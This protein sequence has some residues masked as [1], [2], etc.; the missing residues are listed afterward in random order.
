MKNYLK[1]GLN[2]QIEI[3]KVLGWK[4][5]I[6]ALLVCGY[7]SFII[8]SITV[9]LFPKKILFLIISQLIITI[10]FIFFI[11]KHLYEFT[12]KNERSRYKK[13]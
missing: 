7:M 10:S 8:G 3:K 4:K 9:G 2:K 5:Y 1:G 12:I 11:T 13:F 6:L